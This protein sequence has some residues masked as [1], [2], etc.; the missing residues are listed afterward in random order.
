MDGA[1]QVDPVRSSR[2]SRRLIRRCLLSADVSADAL[3]GTAQATTIERIDVEQLTKRATMIVQG[4]VVATAVEGIYPMQ[5]PDAVGPVC[6][7]K[8]ATVQRNKAATFT[9]TLAKGT[10]RYNVVPAGHAPMWTG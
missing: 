3:P 1:R 9:R 2:S 4:T 7:A 5:P 10:Y 8:H 6:S